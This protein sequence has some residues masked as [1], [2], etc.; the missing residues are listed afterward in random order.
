M[1]ILCC[2]IIQNVAIWYM[3][4][5]IKYVHI[6]VHT[7]VGAKL[8]KSYDNNNKWSFYYDT[9]FFYPYV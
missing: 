9:I 4:A 7:N 3:Y 6:Y 1:F 5:C 8:A 2:N